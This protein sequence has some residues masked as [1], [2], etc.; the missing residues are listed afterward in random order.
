MSSVRVTPEAQARE[1]RERDMAEQNYSNG[2]G[3]AAEGGAGPTA[4]DLR[5]RVAAAAAA[6]AEAQKNRAADGLGGMA[7]A[8]RQ[9]SDQLRGSSAFVA[10]WVNAVGDHLHTLAD[11]LREKDSAELID[12]V[13]AFARRRPALFLGGAFLL[14]VGV[15]QVLKAGGGPGL[16]LPASGT[17]ADYNTRQRRSAGFTAGET[18]AADSTAF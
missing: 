4:A 11:G 3:S 9:A 2:A 10:S 17:S 1:T 13:T 16:S 8:A 12:D 18:S 7:D 14:G 15:A 5:D 6:A